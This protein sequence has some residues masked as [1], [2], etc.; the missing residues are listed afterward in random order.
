[1]FLMKSISIDN[2]IVA[3]F[4][5]LLFAI[6]YYAVNGVFFS[7]F[8]FLFGINGRKN[9]SKRVDFTKS[10]LTLMMWM[11]SFSLISL[12]PEFGFQPAFLSDIYSFWT[13]AIILIA[14]ILIDFLE[15]WIH[16]FFHK[17]PFLWKFHRV[18]HESFEL[19]WS[20]ALRL[21]VVESFGTSL[22]IN[23]FL[24]ILFGKEKLILLV[25]LFGSK[26]FYGFFLHSNTDVAYGKAV[27]YFSSPRFHHWHHA[28]LTQNPLNLSTLFPIWD[29]IFGTYYGEGSE[30]P[31]IY[32]IR[33]SE[34]KLSQNGKTIQV[35]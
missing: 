12:L 1:M 23:L 25:I 30:I 27:L 22:F 4:L 10:M 28:T 13:I 16:L 2:F 3:P 11:L 33:N 19:N 15:Y 20:K 5:M 7:F 34:D 21:S 29:K 35:I 18:H 9:S 14:F 31:R 8:N 26:R 6:I 32:G 24:F 17:S